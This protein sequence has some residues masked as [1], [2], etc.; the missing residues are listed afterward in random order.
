MVGDQHAG[1]NLNAR[2]EP[3]PRLG[4]EVT[5]D[6]GVVAA[7]DDGAGLR[8]GHAVVAA[9]LHEFEVAVARTVDLDLRNLGADPYGQREALLEGLPDEPLQLA[10]GDMP[11]FRHGQ[12]SRMP[13]VSDA[14]KRRML[15]A[16]SPRQTFSSSPW[17]M[18]TILRHVVVC[19]AA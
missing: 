4:F 13:I 8:R 14:P 18:R 3:L 1:E 6:A 16:V 2:F 10:E 17:S 12:P 7:P 5:R 15:R 19:A 9:L 11:F